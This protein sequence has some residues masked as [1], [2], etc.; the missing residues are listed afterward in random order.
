[1]FLFATILFAIL[2]S[3][4]GPPHCSL[5]WL[6]PL[7]H[8]WVA[9]ALGN[10]ATHLAGGRPS[11]TPWTPMEGS[12]PLAVESFALCLDV[13]KATP[14]GHA[15]GLPWH[16]CNRTLMRTWRAVFT[17]MCPF[18]GSTRTTVLAALSAGLASRRHGIHPTCRPAA[19]AAAGA[20][21]SAAAG[22]TLPSLDAILLGRTRTL[23]HVPAAARCLWG[24]VL[25]RALA[26]A[27]HHN[28]IRAWQDLLMLP[29]AVLDAPQR[30][31]RKHAKAVAAYTLDRLQRW[32]SGERAGLWESRRPPLPP[33]GRERTANQRKELA[34]GLAREGFDSKACAALLADGLCAEMPATIT[35]LQQLHPTQPN[36]AVPPFH[37]LCPGPL[38]EPD[39]VS[40]QLSRC[41]R[42]WPLWPPSAAP[43]GCMLPWNYRHPSP[44]LG[45]R[46]CASGQWSGM[47]S[48]GACAPAHLVAVPKPKGGVR[49]I[50][51]GELLRR[52]TGKC[53]MSQLHTSARQHFFPAQVGVAVSGG[54]EAAVHTV[55]AWLDRHS[56]SQNKVLLKLDFENA[57]NTISRDQVLSAVRSHFPALAHGGYLV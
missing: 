24:K 39:M 16:P 11:T 25:T 27:A 17:G 6:R 29:H 46:G 53:L 45:R 43:S 42:S 21:R 9:N 3:L 51:I 32:E 22:D 44:A 30:G 18:L 57:F 56:N 48:G 54:A 12:L 38:V 36:P 50:A 7:A 28:D 26:A 37:E 4:Y 41:I 35:A 10:A 1:M 14:C 33:S 19:R 8:L 34:T 20:P 23:R 49:P 2:S 15:G 52:L 55:R 31:G 40:T 5:P 47:R 13:C